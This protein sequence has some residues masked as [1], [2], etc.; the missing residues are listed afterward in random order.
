MRHA[1]SHR[2]L[3]L[4]AVVM[5]SGCAARPHGPGPDAK[6]H[7]ARPPGNHPADSDLAPLAAAEASEL[8]RL[9]P[10]T[11]SLRWTDSPLAERRGRSVAF[12]LTR[13]DGDDA[14]ER[15]LLEL[16]GATRSIL[17]RGPDGSIGVEREEDPAED[18]VVLYQPAIL[19]LPARLTADRPIVQE[20]SVRVL[21]ARS[22]RERARG[23]VRVEA[24]LLGRGTV[25]TPAGR[26][27]AVW[28]RVVR[29]MDLNLA[30]VRVVIDSAYA[31]QM[32]VVNRVEQT[33]RTLGVFG[34]TTL[35]QTRLG[36]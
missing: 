20:S 15:W 11:G 5:A 35:S 13:T 7:A 8:Y 14:A 30:R 21:S 18:A 31:R 12:R 29:E 9:E 36:P 33:T 34:D 16:A 4:L 6:H 24:T 1:L 28:V 22:G 26:F 2:F 32:R 25:D 27:E 17:V 23:T 3:W 10:R 19:S